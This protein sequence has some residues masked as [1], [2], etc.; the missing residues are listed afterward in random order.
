M[1]AD[2]PAPNL[3]SQGVNSSNFANKSRAH[4]LRSDFSILPSAIRGG[5]RKSSPDRRGLLRLA[6]QHKSACPLASKATTIP[7]SRDILASRHKKRSNQ[8]FRGATAPLPC[9]PPGCPDAPP[10]TVT[11][12]DLYH[13]V[14]LPSPSADKVKTEP[15]DA[16]PLSPPTAPSITNNIDVNDLIYCPFHRRL[17]TPT[18]YL[19]KPW[20]TRSASNPDLPLAGPTA[21]RSDLVVTPTLSS[22]KEFS[23]PVAPF[24]F[25]GSLY[26]ASSCFPCVRLPVQHTRTVLGAPG[27]YSPP[28][29]LKF[30]QIS[31]R[32]GISDHAKAAGKAAI[33]SPSASTHSALVANAA[34]LPENHSILT[35][36]A[37]AAVSSCPPHPVD[38]SLGWVMDSGASRHYCC[39]KDQIHNLNETTSGWVSGLD[40]EIRG[41]G[42]CYIGLTSCDGTLHTMVLHD[43][44]FVPDLV[45]R[46]KD[47]FHR[48]FSVTEACAK[49]WVVTFGG[50]HGDLLTHTASSTSFPLTHHRGL[51]WVP[52][53]RVASPSPSIAATAGTHP[54]KDLL[55]YRLGH[56]H[57]AGISKL[58][59]MDLP[60]VPSSLASTSTSFCS[61]CQTCKS[62]VADI[63][64]SSTRPADPTEPFTTMSVDIWG[65]I[66]V[67]AIGG[68]SWVLGTAC[69]TTSYVMASLMR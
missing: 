1:T 26:P 22:S 4:R 33:F 62:H 27:L 64:R 18:V 12:S 13:D 3:F 45:T 29:H 37:S 60:G 7:S 55:H 66:A 65:P 59:S 63:N 16:L 48:L 8:L 67:S 40:V 23:V 47:H 21:S 31:N 68:Y 39:L 17:V 53:T 57:D 58:A 43:V 24:K 50:S 34:V 5:I 36:H 32:C 49:G 14:L 52:A 9:D 54:S 61:H 35:A 11:D 56:L 51:Y 10:T 42:D 6:S 44:L 30:C 25:S 19:R 28:Q 38:L 41:S 69:H 15:I 20:P 2:L 46:S